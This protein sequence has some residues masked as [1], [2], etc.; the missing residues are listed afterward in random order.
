MPDPDQDTMQLI[1]KLTADMNGIGIVVSE[2]LAADCQSAEN[3][4][5]HMREI[6]A[7][8]G[9]FLNG[10]P[11]GPDPNAQQMTAWARHRAELI[12]LHAQNRMVTG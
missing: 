6:A 1:A 10:A 11:F 4:N 12:L 8:V 9:E 3:P 2:L 7:K 5:E